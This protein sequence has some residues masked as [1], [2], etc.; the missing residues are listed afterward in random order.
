M[1]SVNL[2]NSKQSQKVENKRNA[3]MGSLI[4][5][6]GIIVVFLGIYG[7]VY[8]WGKQVDKKITDVDAQIAQ[9]QENLSVSQKDFDGIHDIYLRLQRS[10]Q[11]SIESVTPSLL[12]IENNILKGVVLSEY[13]YTDK[14]GVAGIVLEGDVT[15]TEAL[16][17]QVEKFRESEVFS[18]VQLTSVGLSDEGFILFTIEMEYAQG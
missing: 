12:G 2:Y 3:D 7:G 9:A 17:Q 11:D 10:T 15:S 4:F 16:L 1:S 6:I 5:S 8:F 13:S 14:E 18:S